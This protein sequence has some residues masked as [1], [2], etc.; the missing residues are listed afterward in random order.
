M[1]LTGRNIGEAQL[2]LSGADRTEA[3]AALETKDTTEFASK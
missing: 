1:I 2:G 3:N